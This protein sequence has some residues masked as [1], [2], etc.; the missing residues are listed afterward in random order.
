MPWIS[1]KKTRLLRSSHPSLT[2][3][4]AM[5]L[6]LSVSSRTKKIRARSIDRK[7]NDV[8][9]KHKSAKQRNGFFLGGLRSLS[10]K[11]DGF[12]SLLSSRKCAK[13]ALLPTGE[14]V[15]VFTRIMDLVVTGSNE[16]GAYRL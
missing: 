4:M 8:N 15:C 6:L 2:L 16:K 10:R 3:S 5:S 14:N 11:G 7:H 13:D 1:K 12:E 9:N